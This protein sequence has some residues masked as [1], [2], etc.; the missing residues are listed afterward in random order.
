MLRDV[1]WRQYP[2]DLLSDDK[3]ACVEAEL[4]DE[5]K[6]APYMFYCAALKL[7]DDD[8]VFDLD[9]GVIFARLM[10]VKDVSTVFEIANLMRKRRIITRLFDDSNL[11]GLVDWTYSD[12]KTRTIEE[13]RKIVKASIE[14]EKAKATSNL[15]FSKD[16]RVGRYNDIPQAESRVGKCNDIPQATVL[17]EK[18]KMEGTA[19]P[20]AGVFLLHENDKNCENVVKEV[21]DDKNAKNVVNIQYNTDNTIHTDIQTTHTHIQ[22]LSGYGPIEGPPP[23]NCSNRPDVAGKTY[24]QTQNSNIANTDEDACGGEEI[25]MLADQAL[26]ISQGMDEEKDKGALIA[27][28]NDFFVKNCYGYKPKQSAYAVKKLAEEIANLSDEVNPPL[29]VAS[30]MCSEFKKMCEGGREEYWKGMPLL[31]ANMIKARALAE[32]IQYAGKILAT[33]QNGNKFLSAA[34]KAKREYEA[35]KNLVGDEMRKE[36]IKYNI[37]P[38]D[39]QANKK[40]LLE[41]AKEAE[42]ARQAQ[43]DEDFEI[44]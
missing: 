19:A 10:R 31:P 2:V 24:E 37:D 41:K 36:F 44:F 26:Q 6:Y 16:G 14:K 28:L 30:V 13:R 23:D 21:F 9:D 15:D 8:G 29:E 20:Q 33:N 18:P 27:Y 7:C 3:M 35:E 17:E 22:Q 25:S 11:C 40:L 43:E 1:Y 4:P 39:P 5:L 34:E 38:E 42:A 32:L 12:K